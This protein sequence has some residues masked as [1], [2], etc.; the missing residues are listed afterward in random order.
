ML[1]PDLVK[2]GLK[3]PNDFEKHYINN[4]KK[5]NRHYSIYQPYPDFNIISY[6]KNNKD[7]QYMSK[8]QLEIHWIKYGRYES[9]IYKNN[10]TINDPYDIIDKILYIN[11][12]SRKDR[13]IEIEE[14]FVKADIPKEKIERISGVY[15]TRGG[16]GCTAS[17]IKC[18]KQ[19]I[20]N[21]WNNV[22]I[23]ED[24]FNFID[25]IELVKNSIKTIIDFYNDWDVIFFSGNVY[26][27]YPFN[28]M[29]SKAIN[30]QCGSGY[31][32][33]SSYYSRLLNNLEEGYKLFSANNIPS[34]YALDIYWKRLQP[35]DKWY[36]FNTK[37]GYQRN[38]Y[39]DI[40][41]RVVDYR[42]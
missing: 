4:G 26:R 36:V 18:L 39:S 31:L 24:D 34:L 11:L 22:L 32:V 35:I 29:F 27:T 6:R 21:E 12:D 33:N 40:E 7:L 13:R 25:N 17:H 37:L 8:G 9:R 2:A 38:S 15:N 16:L 19:A 14:Q 28:E 20:M 3:H 5:E 1:N 30:V 42:C 41:K 10:T 23:L